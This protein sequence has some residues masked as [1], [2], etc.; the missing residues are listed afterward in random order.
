VKKVLALISQDERLKRLDQEM[1]DAITGY[2]QRAEFLHKQKLAL[3]AEADKFSDL[4][5]EEI[6]AVL[7]EKGLI[8]EDYTVKKYALWIDGGAIHIQ[9]SKS[10]VEQGVLSLR[11]LVGG[12]QE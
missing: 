7:S 10:L 3:R 2:A 4:K 12:E 1:Q 5:W 9:D 11:D 8:P 6:R